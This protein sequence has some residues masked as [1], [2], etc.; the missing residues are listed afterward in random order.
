MDAI[1]SINATLLKNDISNV[2]DMIYHHKQSVLVER[3]GRPIAK[4]VPYQT[5]ENELELIAEAVVGKIN[6][7][8]SAWKNVRS[9]SAWQHNLRKNEDK[10]R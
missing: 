1:T 9:A 6:K 5:E 7:N 8:K 3:Y 10:R 2:L 4:I